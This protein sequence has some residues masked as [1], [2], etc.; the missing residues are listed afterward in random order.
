MISTIANV[1]LTIFSILVGLAVAL[2]ISSLLLWWLVPLAFPALSF[3]FW[4]AVPLAAIL[5]LATAPMAV[6]R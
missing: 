1:L 6:D 3:G 5:L 2:G 4:N